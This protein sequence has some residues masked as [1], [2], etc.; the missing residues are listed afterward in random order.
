MQCRN[1]HY[2]QI[3]YRAF[4]ATLFGIEIVASSGESFIA[5]NPGERYTIR[6]GEIGFVLAIDVNTT[7][8]IQRFVD[9][10][11]TT[12]EASLDLQT[13]RVCLLTGIQ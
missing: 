6:G 13:T 4:H 7:H 3:I 5:I 2:S 9:T 8:R 10:S 12:T 11:N 1:S